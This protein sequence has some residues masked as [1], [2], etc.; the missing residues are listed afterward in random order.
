MTPN[1]K[2][3]LVAIAIISIV[4]L[5]TALLYTRVTIP[6]GQAE[7]F[8]TFEEIDETYVYV[9]TQGNATCQ[10]TALLPPSKLADAMKSVVSQLG[11]SVINQTYSESI[12]GGWAQCG[13]ET[14]N[15]TCAVTGLAAG[16]NF[17]LTMTWKIPDI[18]RRRDN[19]WTISLD[20][21]DN[22]SVAQDIIAT[23]NSAW[24]LYR[25]ISKNAHS[26]VRTKTTVVLPDGA[27]NV[28]SP[29]INSSYTT[30]YGGGS[31]GSATLYTEQIGGRTAIIENDLGLL[32]TEN[33]MTLT[34]EH[35]L[36]NI[37]FQKVDYDGAFSTDNWSFISSIG[38]L[39]L[40]LKYGRELDEQYSIF[41]GGSKYSLSPAQL[42]YYAADAIV[43]LNQ[44]SQFS[45][46]Q[47]ISVTSPGIENGDLGTFWGSL[48]KAEYV[49][50]AQ[51]VRDN[52]ASTGAA[53]GIINTPRGQ[54]RFKDALLTFTRIL[55]AYEENG[56]LP[57]TIMLAPSSSGQLSWGNTA[58][59]A[60]YAYF[61]LPD[62]YVITN[63]T[64]VNQVL[65]NV[66][67]P[68]YDNVALASALCSWGHNNISYTLAYATTPLTSEW[69]LEHKQGQCREYTNANLALLRTAGIPAKR[70]GGWIVLTGT[71]QPPAEL[72]PFMKGT[73]PDGRTIGSHAWTRVYLPGK[74][75]TFDDSTWGYFEN[76]LY[77]IYQQQEQTWMGALAG[78]ETAYGRI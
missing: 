59:P 47:P 60:N 22:Q 66:R 28:S 10:F 45:I 65:D 48:T 2:F 26:Y 70:M 35:L 17:K 51:Q 38:R 33:E 23:F 12:K 56:V 5:S 15:I 8:E 34:V 42:L 62:T 73:T 71:W 53:P 74:G 6:A 39:R 61:L 24:T 46:Q 31:Y 49:S 52:I 36:E 14:E 16:E 78:Y 72:A 25:N 4:S 37:V 9:D 13:L 58:V 76:T 40:D 68:G 63:T 64:L 75:W 69:V 41:I 1:Q 57:N 43:A 30:D 7:N 77:D 55:F 44:G 50:L 20:W 29:H 19:H 11:T 21:V 67:Q 27:D 3:V 54:I 18:A 32:S